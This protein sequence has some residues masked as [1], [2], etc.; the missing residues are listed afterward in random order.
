MES[1]LREFIVSSC[2]VAG[3]TRA[4]SLHC[5]GW[6]YSDTVRVTLAGRALV[7]DTIR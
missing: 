1:T 4:L 6:G 7:I 3:G 5:G 2:E